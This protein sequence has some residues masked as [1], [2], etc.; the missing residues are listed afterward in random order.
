MKGVQQSLNGG[1]GA[2][3]WLW[4]ATRA[5]RGV[6]CLDRAA[7]IPPPPAPFIFKYHP[8]DFKEKI[9]AHKMASFSGASGLFILLL[10]PGFLYN[11][12]FHAHISVCVTNPGI[13]F[14]K[15]FYSWI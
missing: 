2:L 13:I 5:L 15:Q 3:G 11:R 6:W 4:E 12:L 1:P 7:R 10:L 8:T 9:N 14:R